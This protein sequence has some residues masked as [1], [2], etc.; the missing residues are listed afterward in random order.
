MAHIPHGSP[1]GKE[2][3]YPQVSSPDRRGAL[4]Y[5]SKNIICKYINDR[6]QAGSRWNA[7]GLPQSWPGS[8]ANRG[9]LETTEGM[10]ASG[11]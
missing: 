10:A 3:E 8:V 7:M 1:Y 5:L 4:K 2:T 9:P 6:F 11:G